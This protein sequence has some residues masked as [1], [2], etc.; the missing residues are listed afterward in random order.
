MHIVTFL[1]FSAMQQVT[2]SGLYFAPV[3]RFILPERMGWTRFRKAVADFKQLF[4]ETVQQHK[5]T[6]DKSDLR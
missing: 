2:D 5:E 1:M 4:E 6:L 3:L